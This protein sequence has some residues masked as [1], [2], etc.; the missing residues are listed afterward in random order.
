MARFDDSTLHDFPDRA[1][2]RLQ[3]DPANLH[4]LI[5]SV[6]PNLVERFDFS[7]VE[8]VGREFLLEDWRRRESDLLF[9]LPF[10]AAVEGTERWALVCVL[11]EHQSEPDPAM[12][13]RVLLYAVLF[14]E[15]EWRA[16]EADHPE[17]EPLRLTPV[18]PIV[19][20]TGA[21][22]W[23]AY[24]ELIDLIGGPDEL[25]RFAPQWQPLFWDLAERTPEELI[26]AAGAWLVSL[27][28]VRAERADRE[29]FEE[30]FTAVLQRL[31]SLSEPERMRWRDLLWFVLSWALRRRPSGERAGLLEAARS[32]QM[33]VKN[34]E[35]VAA[36]TETVAET[37]EQELIARGRADGE[38][39]A[40]IDTRRDD[41]RLLLE[42]RFGP[43]P[44]PL[45]Q[46]IASVEDPERLRNALRQVVHLSSLGDLEL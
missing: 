27:A 20:H 42:E 10:R 14:W 33:E 45:A 34:R 6:L 15:R 5:A 38:A 3:A 43:L 7:R 8:E 18:I 25:R 12:P 4:D 16:W 11:I 40:K 36:L 19:F 31:E 29:A 13:L 1:I 32:S 23:R 28:V 26:Q 22:A 17:A 30:V 37:W 44:E 35:E 46:Q 41:L 9:R 2:R 39:R 24:R 21:R